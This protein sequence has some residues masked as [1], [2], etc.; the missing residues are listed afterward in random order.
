[1]SVPETFEQWHQR[2]HGGPPNS[3]CEFYGCRETYEATDGSEL[4][5]LRAQLDAAQTAL[6][7]E[8]KTSHDLARVVD[9]LKAQLD[10]AHD[11][12]RAALRVLP[13]AAHHAGDGVT[14]EDFVV[15]YTRAEWDE[16]VAA[17]KQIDAAL[18]GE[19]QP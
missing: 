8:V 5:R 13:V 2:R 10:A 9:G 12:L 1:M 14:S 3:N 15:P 7:V 19:R 4:A 17:T 11:A 16:L 6:T 18:V